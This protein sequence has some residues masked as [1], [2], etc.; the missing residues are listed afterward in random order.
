MSNIHPEKNLKT[1]GLLSNWWRIFLSEMV[2]STILVCEI[3][4]VWKGITRV[5]LSIEEFPF[6]NEK[7]DT[8]L[9]LKLGG[10]FVLS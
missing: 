3:I 4:S 1:K 5:I 2:T 8:V 9:R 10:I 7:C 6:Q